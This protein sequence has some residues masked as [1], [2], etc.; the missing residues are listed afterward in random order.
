MD[1]RKI[2]LL[3]NFLCQAIDQV[4]EKDKQI[5]NGKFRK[6]SKQ[7][8]S[9]FDLDE[10]PFDLDEVHNKWS[11]AKDGKIYLNQE[12]EYYKSGKW[13]RK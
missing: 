11:M 8:L 7:K 5:A 13:R 9:Q 2:G 6:K 4:D 1:C 3:R 10:L 12:G